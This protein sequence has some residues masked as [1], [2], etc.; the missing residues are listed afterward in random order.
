MLR[1]V[2]A[3]LLALSPSRA[4]AAVDEPLSLQGFSGLLDTPTA[5]T[6]APGSAHLLFTNQ[7]DPRFRSADAMRTYALSIGFFRYLEVGGRVS[8]T[9]PSNR[10]GAMRD[11]SFNAKLRLPLDLL[12]PGLPIAVAVGTQ[13]EGGAATHFRTRYAVV[14][15]R[16]W[17]LA[18]S[19]GRGHGQR[20][21]GIFGGLSLGLLPFAEALA[22]WDAREWNAGI[23][24][25]LPIR[26]FS[27]PLRL[28]AIAKISL[29]HQPDHWEWAATLSVPLGLGESA[30]AL[31][32]GDGRTARP[33]ASSPGAPG[34]QGLRTLPGRRSRSS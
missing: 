9:L 20:M 27:V 15:L 18:G 17:R 30:Q 26:V 31:A 32:H 34:P 7:L 14:T 23:R 2:L 24:L 3:A 6:H 29:S 33:P 1:A 25:S 28:G 12:F 4:S 22:D 8:E 16:A 10:P 5:F 21:N 19:L 13:D 11:L